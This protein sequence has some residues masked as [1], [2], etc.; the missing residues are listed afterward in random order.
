MIRV[1]IADD[2]KLLV[3]SLKSII[4]QDGENAVVGC[5]RDGREA[6][7]LCQSL[8]PDIVLMDIN[9]PGC[10]GVEGTRLIKAAFDRIK[11]LVLTVL[12]DEQTIR[13]ALVNGADGYVLKDVTPEGL[14]QVIKDTVGGFGVVSAKAYET[15]RREL[16]GENAHEHPAPHPEGLGLKERELHL[17]GLI[18]AGKN[19]RQ[20]AAELFLSEG[21]V[22]NIIT[23]LLEKL[24]LK[25]RYELLSFAYKNNLIR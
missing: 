22:K 13:R 11:V 8:T 20:I 16:S 12:E 9:M 4:E 24:N 23:E 7:E 19:N 21:R 3:D 17:I 18:A 1:L 6:L 25:S 15:I 2:Q 14:K 10:D 5:A